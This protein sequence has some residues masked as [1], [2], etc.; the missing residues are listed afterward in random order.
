MGSFGETRKNVLSLKNAELTS[1]HVWRLQ[2]TGI[3]QRSYHCFRITD[4][5]TEVGR[6]GHECLA[7]FENLELSLLETVFEGL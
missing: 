2:I 7:A 4:V 1:R 6:T 3:V 5:D